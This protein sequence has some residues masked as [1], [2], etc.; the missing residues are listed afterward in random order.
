[1]FRPQY[2][3]QPSSAAILNELIEKHDYVLY[4]LYQ[5]HHHHG[6]LC[7]TDALLL[8][9]SVYR[10]AREKAHLAFHPYSAINYKIKKDDK[11]GG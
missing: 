9:S 6:Y 11:T 3:S 1:M 10:S 5:C 4:N 2:E 8:H 7:Q